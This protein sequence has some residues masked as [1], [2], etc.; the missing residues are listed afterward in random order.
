MTI[1][2]LDIQQLMAK[3]WQHTVVLVLWCSEV[4]IHWNSFTESY[5]LLWQLDPL[6]LDRA[7]MKKMGTR[8]ERFEKNLK[9]WI[10]TNSFKALTRFKAFLKRCLY[11]FQVIL[12]EVGENQTQRMSDGCFDCP[13][14]QAYKSSSLDK[15][16]RG[17]WTDMFPNAAS[18]FASRT[19]A[20][21][22]EIIDEYIYYLSKLSN[23]FFFYKQHTMPHDWSSTSFALVYAF[24]IKW[25]ISESTYWIKVLNN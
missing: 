10:T 3:Q 13:E 24:S 21:K 14:D 15:Q 23:I 18:V 9:Y 6:N 17:F 11:W 8:N 19:A 25:S 2:S 16:L 1:P 22:I 20:A 4:L 7:E 5:W 12:E